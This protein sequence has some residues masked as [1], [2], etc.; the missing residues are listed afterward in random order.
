MEDGS[1]IFGGRMASLP[2]T[3]VYGDTPIADL[4]VSL[5]AHRAFGKA[6]CQLLWFSMTVFFRILI[7]F[8]LEDSA[9]PFPC[10]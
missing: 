9:R 5:S 6:E 2:Y 10:G 4:G 1:M 7:R 3:R 8:L